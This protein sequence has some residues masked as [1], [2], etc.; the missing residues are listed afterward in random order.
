LYN[1]D[2]KYFLQEKGIVGLQSIT[3]A[4]E[5]ELILYM[6]LLILLY[7]DDTVLMA[8]SADDLQNAYNVKLIR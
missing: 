1:N 4:T 3:D 8:E 5:N 6:K 7:A 2:L